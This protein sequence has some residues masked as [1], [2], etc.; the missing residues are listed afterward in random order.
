M[1]L[2]TRM[3]PFP[4]S[5]YKSLH[6]HKGVAKRRPRKAQEAALGCQ[7]NGS[8]APLR[9]LQ[10]DV[11][12]IPWPGAM[13]SPY[14]I[15]HHMHNQPTLTPHPLPHVCML[16]HSSIR[17]CPRD[18][19]SSSQVCHHVCMATPPQASLPACCKMKGGSSSLTCSYFTKMLF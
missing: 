12:T 18:L 2:S 7:G 17:A 19:G 10:E 6:F 16:V 13:H 9:A 14:C 8:F 11:G 15:H 3:I 4:S 5:Q 1:Q